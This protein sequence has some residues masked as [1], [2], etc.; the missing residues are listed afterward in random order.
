MSRLGLPDF[1][2]LAGGSQ[3]GPAPSFGLGSG[4]GVTAQLQSQDFSRRS[5]ELLQ[6]RGIRRTS[7]N[8]GELEKKTNTRISDLANQLL[9]AT[10]GISGLQ[11]QFGGLQNQVGGFSGQ[12][13]DLQNQFGGQI[14]GLQ[15]QLSGLQDQLLGLGGFVPGPDTGSNTM[16]RV[17]AIEDFLKSLGL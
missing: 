16:D 13:N 3:A 7:F 14:G 10:G 8:I 5:N 12:I 6:E 1:F 4:T 15:S 2:A 17:K 11:S 9:G